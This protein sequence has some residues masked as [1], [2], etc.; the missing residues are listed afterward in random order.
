MRDGPRGFR[1][2]SSCPALLRCRPLSDGVAP[3]GVSPS[4][5]GLSRPFRFHRRYTLAGPTTP[6]PP[7]RR[8]FGL[9]PF[10]SPL[11]WESIVPRV[12][13]PR[14]VTGLQPAGLPHSDTHGSSHACRSPCIFAACRVLLRLRKPRHPPSALV[15]STLV[16][17]H[18]GSSPSLP[19]KSSLL[20]KDFLASFS[21]PRYLSQY[22]Q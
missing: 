5:P 12:R 2:D 17:R 22:C 19:V 10:R 1:Q 3:T 21:L 4:A 7:R 18:S 11:L 15:T 6:A 13:P 9:L 14:G 16:F 8:R 20:R